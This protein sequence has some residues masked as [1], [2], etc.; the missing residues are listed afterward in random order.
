MDWLANDNS[1]NTTRCNHLDDIE[2]PVYM[3]MANLPDIDHT[4]RPN[5]IQK[6]H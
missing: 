4:V 2:R 1:L 6:Q 3:A 5:K